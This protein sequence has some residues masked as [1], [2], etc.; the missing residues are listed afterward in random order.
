MGR[1]QNNMSIGWVHP[2]S[3]HAPPLAC[4]SKITCK[5]KYKIGYSKLGKYGFHNFY[6]SLDHNSKFE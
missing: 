4:G 6:Q 3:T 5:T 1:L 2:K